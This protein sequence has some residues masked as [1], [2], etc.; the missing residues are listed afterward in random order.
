MGPGTGSIPRADPSAALGT[1]SEVMLTIDKKTLN[2]MEEQH[3]GHPGDHR[4]LRGG[5]RTGLHPLR[6]K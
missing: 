1:G 6:V 3:T 4:L 5:R 2:Q